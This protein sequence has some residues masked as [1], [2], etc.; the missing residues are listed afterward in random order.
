MKAGIVNSSLRGSS[1]GTRF[2]PMKVPVFLFVS[3]CVLLTGKARALELHPLFTDHAVLQ[4]ELPVPVW[5]TAEP[6]ADV[7]VTFAGQTH[8]SKAD[9]KGNWMVVLDPLLADAEPQ[10]L[11]VSSGEKIVAVDDVLIGEVWVGSGQSNMAWT[12]SRTF[13]ADQTAR[14]AEEGSFKGIRL[15]KVP[16]S[17][18]DERESSVNA[19]W[20]L[21]EK[22]AVLNFSAAAFYFAARLARDRSVPV[23]IIQSANGG[24][25]AYSWINSETRDRDP[26][27]DTVRSYWAAMLKYYPDNLKKYEAALAKWKEKSAAAKKAG[28]TFT[29]RAPQAPMGKDHVKR[30]SGHYNAMVAPLQPYAIRGVIWYQGEANSRVPFNTGY[31]DLMLA[32]VEGWR[33]DWA[34]ASGGDVERRDFPFYL[35]QLPNFA[36]G[37]PDGWPIIRE[38]MLKFWEEGEN[39]GMVVAI[40]KGEADDIHP[41]DKKPVGER[42]ASFARANTYG[43]NI[44]FTGPVYDSLQIEGDKAIVKFRYSE[45][46]LASLDKQPLKYFEIAGADATFHPAEAGIDGDRLIVTS[47]KVAEPRAVRYAWKSNPEGANFGNQEGFPASPFRTDSW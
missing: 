19:S 31:K 45:A 25:N 10:S 46:G 21:P 29:V 43:E 40:D 15:F 4:Q 7:E 9:A 44:T 42:L 36:G 26:A 32:L 11:A 3:A 13:T 47:E 41:R 30:P 5:G 14:A 17:G 6:D 34:T 2:V 18:A 39:T 24:T 12:V 35:V 33:G 27:A 37:D 20:A 38:Q 8:E 22:D 28:E 16:V 23:G 1:A